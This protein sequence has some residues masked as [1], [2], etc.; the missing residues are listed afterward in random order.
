M[1][2]AGTPG[3]HCTNLTIRRITKSAD[4]AAQVGWRSANRWRQRDST[5]FRGPE[6]TPPGMVWLAR[7]TVPR[8]RRKSLR[9]RTSVSGVQDK[10]SGPPLGPARRRRHDSTDIQSE[11]GT[12][13]YLDWWAATTAR[14]CTTARPTPTTRPTCSAQK[15]V[16][17]IN[18]TPSTQPLF[19][20]FAPPR[21]ARPGDA[22]G[23]VRDR[24]RRPHAAALAE[25]RRDRARRAGVGAGA[26]VERQHAQQKS[27]TLMVNRC[28]SLLA[29]DDAVGKI[30]QTLQIHRPAL[31]HADRVRLRQRLVGRL[32]PLAGQAGAVEREPAGAA[33]H[34]LG[35]PHHAG[36]PRV[37]TSRSTSTGRRRSPTPPASRCPG[38][39]EGHSLLPRTERRLAGPHGLPDRGLRPRLDADAR[40]GCRPT[41]A[42]ARCAGST[43]S[44]RPAR[45]SS[46]TSRPIPTRCTTSPTIRPTPRSSRPMH[47]RMVQLCSPPPPGFTP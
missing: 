9:G 41:A 16:D 40:R 33:D 24:L 28:R 17:F 44:T 22:P 35:R 2:E 32:A 7:I 13:G 30:V 39:V 15:S 23:A 43:S 14:V 4:A 19:L 6:R 27:D 46:T 36:Q 5:R 11:E 3:D 26:D 12:G 34:A 8:V 42:S 10:F 45:S 20:W 47:A 1:A 37:G 25:R 18:S 38:D 31:E 29:V 21:A